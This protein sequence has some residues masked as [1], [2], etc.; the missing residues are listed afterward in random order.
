V[1]GLHPGTLTFAAQRV[2][3]TSA[4]QV[5]TVNNPGATPLKVTSITIS[6]DFAE[7]NDCPSK[8][9]AGKN[10]TIN[11]TFSPTQTGT[12]TGTL[13]IKDSTLITLAGSGTQSGLK[14]A[15]NGSSRGAVRRGQM[16]SG[17]GETRGCSTQGSALANVRPPK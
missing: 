4:A 3:T 9:T 5:V 8:L 15:S 2:G 1:I 13:S 7:A 17:P 14:R 11:V 16:H 10:C 12:R 6:G